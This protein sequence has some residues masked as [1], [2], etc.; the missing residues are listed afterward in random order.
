MDN[1]PPSVKLQL[2]LINRSPITQDLRLSLVGVCVEGGRRVIS[3]TP[4]GR[5]ESCGRDLN[6]ERQTHVRI[7]GS[8]KV[9][10][11]PV[12]VLSATAVTFWE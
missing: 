5:A 12:S 10:R 11:P 4:R 3:A 6:P 8:G 2:P 1:Q 7:P 9:P